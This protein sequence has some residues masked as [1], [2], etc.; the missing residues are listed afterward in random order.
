MNCY[1]SG[2]IFPVLVAEQRGWPGGIVYIKRSEK[3]E[4]HT[5]THKAI[6]WCSV[7]AFLYVVFSLNIY[8][9]LLIKDKMP[10]SSELYNL[11]KTSMP[12]VFKP[13]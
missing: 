4:I 12:P 6:K 8:E 10:T 2:S 3:G 1:F 13:R 7:I 11:S 5:H 9:S